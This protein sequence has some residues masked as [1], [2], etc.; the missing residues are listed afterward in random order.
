M[1]NWFESHYTGAA[2]IAHG[3][4]AERMSLAGAR[5]LDFG[6]GDGITAF[7]VARLGAGAVVGVDI[8]E[9]F[10]H[11]PDL[12]ETNL[13]SRETPPNLHFVRVSPDCRLPFAEGAFDAAYTWS[14]FEHLAD[15]PAALAA[16]HRVLR[17]GGHCLIQIDPLYHSPF[18]SHLR[19]L[20]DVP[21]GHLLASTAAFVARAQGAGDEADNSEKGDLLYTQN[22]FAGYKRHLIEQFLD[23][24]RLTVRQLLYYVQ[25]SGLVPIQAL[26]GRV[27]GE[28]IPPPV[29]LCAHPPED[30][31]TSTLYLVLRKP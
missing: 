7:G 21:W 22:D 13:G 1:D 19:R 8:N 14:V 17:R 15:V 31:L 9:S 11:L 29:L 18:G 26:P 12:A 23:L 20:V 3:F 4:L 25:S 16:L 28:F 5:I 2:R 10:R 27:S 30:L 6:C 24:N